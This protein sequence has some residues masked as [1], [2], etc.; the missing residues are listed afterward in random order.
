[1]SEGGT[2]SWIVLIMGLFGGLALFLFGMQK[3][4]E[5]FKKSAGKSMRSIL[6]RITKNRFVGLTAGAFV[7]LVIQSSSATTV[8]L[9]GFV[10]AQLLSFTQTL[11]VILGANIGTTFT[12][13]IIAFR[14][15]DYALLMV[16]LGFALSSFAKKEKYKYLGESILGF[17]IL[18]LGMKFMSDAMNPLRDYPGF[19]NMIK[20]L[21]N[22]V[23]GL[24][25]GA[26]IT[27]LIQSS[28]AFTGIIIVL[29]QQGLI[30][31]EAS[32]PML[33]GANI[34]TCVTAALST[35]GASRDAKRVAIA[36]VIFNTLGALAFLFWIP[37]F[38]DIVRSVS[39]ASDVTGMAK[40]AA[41]TPRQIA[42]A[43]TLFNVS[44]GLVFLPFTGLLA[45]LI[46]LIFPIREA[47]KTPVLSTWHLDSNALKTPSVA[48]NLCMAEIGRM[49]KILRRMLEGL[50]Y[51]LIGEQ[52]T[53]DR[54]IRGYGTT[55]A[56]DMREQ[57][58][59]FLQKAI[60]DYLIRIGGENLTEMQSNEN[61]TLISITRSMEAIGDIIHRDMLPLIR[62]KEQKGIDFSVEGKQDIKHYCHKVIKQLRR[63]EEL[64]SEH[65]ISRGIKIVSKETEYADLDAGFRKRHLKRLYEDRKESRVTHEMHLEVMDYFKQIN[66]YITGIARSMIH[67][68]EISES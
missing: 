22:P 61:A 30:T 29:A 31:L 16:I 12:A 49:A 15:T 37:T 9:V 28:S 38:A 41:E 19:I 33:L 50:N 47:D 67:I 42:N 27:A 52:L 25:A 65:S 4:S 62:K 45:K 53:D 66:V 58:I 24:L 55:K 21:D 8:M 18:F 40:L 36:H 57:K 44:L 17:G 13:Q 60:T 23:Y 26:L 11:S 48:L 56:L 32:I 1:M 63:L 5:G 10:Q 43:H 2:I 46:Y 20:N 54:E 14:I 39:P 3:M 51:R 7:T 6:A 68:S 35:I 64:F 59:D 34:G